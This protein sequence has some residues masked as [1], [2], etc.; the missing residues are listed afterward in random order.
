MQDS[1]IHPSDP[2]RLRKQSLRIGN[3]TGAVFRG[4]LLVDGLRV[5]GDVVAVFLDAGVTPAVP[6]RNPYVSILTVCQLM[7]IVLSFPGSSPFCLLLFDHTT[8]N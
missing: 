5:G 3:L 8:I 7:M 4:T 1:A 6:A 2:F